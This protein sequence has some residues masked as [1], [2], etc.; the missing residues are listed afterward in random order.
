MNDNDW[1]QRFDDLEKL[2]LVEM[3]DAFYTDDLYF[4][5]PDGLN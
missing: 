1:S 2:N 4:T 3:E 5:N